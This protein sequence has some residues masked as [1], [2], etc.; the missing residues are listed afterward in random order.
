M[1][2]GANSRLLPERA[3]TGVY[4]VDGGLPSADRL[5][6]DPLRQRRTAGRAALYDLAEPRRLEGLVQPTAGPAQRPHCY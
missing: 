6:R 4:T 1:E 2:L 3:P 5:L